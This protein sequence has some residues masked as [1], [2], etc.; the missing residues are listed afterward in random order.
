VGEACLVR[1]CEEVAPLRFIGLGGPCVEVTT[2]QMPL[3]EVDPSGVCVVAPFLCV[4]TPPMAG[5]VWSFQQS[6]PASVPGHWSQC[7][8]PW[9]TF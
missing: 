5:L 8:S 6:R 3:V 1:S 4:A 2:N 7:R 9:V